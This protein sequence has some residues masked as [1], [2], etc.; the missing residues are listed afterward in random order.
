MI[1]IVVGAFEKVF[2]EDFYRPKFLTLV[3]TQ[4]SVITTVNTDAK[5]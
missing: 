1:S 4:T 5:N 3:I 2:F